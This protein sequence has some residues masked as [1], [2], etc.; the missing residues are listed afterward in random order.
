MR[1]IK[2]ETDGVGHEAAETEYMAAAKA[3]KEV[4]DRVLGKNPE[5]LAVRARLEAAKLALEG[6][7]AL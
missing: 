5:V 4:I 1:N 6:Y 2:K 7:P 3:E